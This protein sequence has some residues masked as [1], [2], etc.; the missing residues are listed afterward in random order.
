MF[1][2]S[3]KDESAGNPTTLVDGDT[4]LQIDK[5]FAFMMKEQKATSSNDQ[6][7]PVHRQPVILQHGILDSAA[8]WMLNREKSIAFRLV[9]AGFDVWMNNSRGSVYSL[10]HQNLP[11]PTPGTHKLSKEQKKAQEKYF[12]FSFHELGIFDQP[13]LWKFVMQMTR[14]D[15]IMYIGHSQGCT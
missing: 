14:Q 7:A 13:A 4:V 5:A 11:R 2:L 1:R 9:K 15:K 12:D 8:C 3:L 10:D 6:S